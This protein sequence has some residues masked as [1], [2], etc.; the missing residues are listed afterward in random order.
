MQIEYHQLEWVADRV[1]LHRVGLEI[2]YHL[3]SGF[4]DRVPPEWVCR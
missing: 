3:R 4:V 2:E 1:P